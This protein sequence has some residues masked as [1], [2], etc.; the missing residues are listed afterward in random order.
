MVES[1]PCSL[2]LTLLFVFL[3]V[4]VGWDNVVT[5]EQDVPNDSHKLE[6]VEP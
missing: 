5:A 6:R 4:L 3:R 1:F 2:V